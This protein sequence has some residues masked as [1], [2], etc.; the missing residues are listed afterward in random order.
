MSESIAFTTPMRVEATTTSIREASKGTQGWLVA[1]DEKRFIIRWDT[2][3]KSKCW[4]HEFKYVEGV[5]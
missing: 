5:D 2:G 3:Q 4:E 1:F